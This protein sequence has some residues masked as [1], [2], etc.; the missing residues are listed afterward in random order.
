MRRRSD[1]ADAVRVGYTVTKKIGG[2]VT[3]NRIKR[4]LRALCREILPLHGDSETDYVL[5][6]RAAAAELEFSDLR[7]ELTRALRRLRRDAPQ[8]ALP[9]DAK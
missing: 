3:R 9:E 5:I 2:A 4:R 7:D 1:G 8:T 6:A